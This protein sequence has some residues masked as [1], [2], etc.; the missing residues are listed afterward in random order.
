MSPSQASASG[1]A[2]FG[3]GAH[4]LQS[5]AFPTALCLMCWGVRDENR[6]HFRETHWLSVTLHTVL[7]TTSLPLGLVPSRILT[8]PTPLSDSEFG[9]RFGVGKED[10]DQKGGGY[11]GL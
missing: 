6:Q 10:W 4:G 11:W 8:F 5:T 3:L 1:H 7:A 9:F 2:K